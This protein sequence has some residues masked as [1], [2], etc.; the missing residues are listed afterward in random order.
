[1]Q[2]TD[3]SEGSPPCPMEAGHRTDEG[4]IEVASGVS[5][6]KCT[7]TWSMGDGREILCAT[8]SWTVA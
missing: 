5:K 7:I 2:V 1:M 4:A 8:A 3:G 6:L